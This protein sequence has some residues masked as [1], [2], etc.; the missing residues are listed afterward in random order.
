MGV[1]MGFVYVGLRKNRFPFGIAICYEKKG[2]WTYWINR[3][4]FFEYMGI[5]DPEK[6]EM[7]EEKK[8]L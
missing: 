2:S 5:P 7:N 4:K 1:G 8:K 3:T 6:V